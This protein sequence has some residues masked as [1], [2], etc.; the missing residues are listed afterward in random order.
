MPTRQV[1]EDFE[2][3]AAE[4]DNAIGAVREIHPDH[5][6]VWIENRGDTR[7]DAEHIAS[8]HDG[9]VLLEADGLPERLREAIAHAH[10]AESAREPDSVDLD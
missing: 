10:D 2:V 6:V 8:A 4:G 5:L 1:H 9:K 7:I 3:F